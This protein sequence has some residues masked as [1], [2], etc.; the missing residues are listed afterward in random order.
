MNIPSIILLGLALSIDSMI[1]AITCG[2]Q[3]KMRLTKGMYISFILALC[4]GLF[5][6]LGAILGGVF[7]KQIEAYDHWV[8]FGLLT[9]IGL[10][11][12]LDV[13]NV[14]K[15]NGL[16]FDISK[17]IIVLGLG[18]ATSI[19]AFISGIGLGIE[20]TV[21][22]DRLIACVI[23]AVITFLV[24]MLGIMFGRQNRFFPAKWATAISGIVLILLGVKILF[25]HNVF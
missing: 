25:E 12:L 13:R 10:K 17:F 9:M 16:G 5:P 24:S 1:V 3:Y 8:A 20:I 22:R 11:M 4:Q 23:I 2:M 14:N 18:V 6:F 21:F 15:N 7:Q 19:D